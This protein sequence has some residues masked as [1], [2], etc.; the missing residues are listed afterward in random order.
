ML[1]VDF[2]LEIDADM[3]L[4]GQGADPEVVRKRRPGLVEL[5]ERAIEL[6]RALFSLQVT[7]RSLRTLGLRH[8]V[9]DLEGGFTLSGERVAQYLGPSQQVHLVVCTIGD[10]VEKRC[11]EL[12][13]SDPAL[14]LALDGFGTVAVDALTS[15]VCQRLVDEA[16]AAGLQTSI[17]LSPGM[18][19]WE[20]GA[21][22]S[23]LFAALQPDPAV[24]RLTPSFQMVP[25]KSASFVVGA[26]VQM[27]GSREACQY[28]SAV[29][30][31]RYRERHCHQP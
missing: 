30:T 28:C 3:V 12:Y 14:S 18:I 17:P 27:D 26:G 31:C 20:L 19:G 1:T 13:S 25:R 15:A 10:G 24:V 22:Q 6:G 16:A 11:S 2:E 7:H 21:G 23:E 9:L 8:T 29:E 4:R 5:A